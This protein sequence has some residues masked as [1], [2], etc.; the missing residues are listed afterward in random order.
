[1]QVKIYHTIQEV[2][3]FWDTNLP[4]N[5]VLQLQ[6][7]SIIEQSQVAHVTPLYIVAY[8]GNQVVLQAY[9][10]ILKFVPSFIHHGSIAKPMRL[11]ARLALG[12]GNLKL[13]VI[14]NLFRHDALHCNVNSAVPDAQNTYAYVMQ[15]VCKQIKHT[16]VLLKDLPEDYAL[17]FATKKKFTRFEND[18]AMYMPIPE[19]WESIADYEKALKKKYAKRYRTTIAQFEN[20]TEKELSLQD[21]TAQINEIH[22][23]YVQ[24]A[25]NQ[26]LTLGLLN[27]NYFINFKKALGDQLKVYGYYADGKLIAFSTAILHH[28]TYDMNYIGFDYHANEKYSVYFNMLFKFIEH[29]MLYN[30]NEL[31]LGR[32]ALEAKAIV[33]CKPR[34]I[35]GLYSINNFVYRYFTAKFAIRTTSAQGDMWLQRHPFK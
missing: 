24:V 13:L 27:K 3:S 28:N 22:E 19:T 15:E 1:M 21:V 14:G 30:C 10:Q 29:A 18:I 5:H 8:K 31:V 9:A 6:Q 26:S 7:L 2:A 17:P 25:K 12:C 32:T 35:N 11:L 23:L 4:T 33:G 34:T 16:A 20:I